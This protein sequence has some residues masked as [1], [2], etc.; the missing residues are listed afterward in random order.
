M[1]FALCHLKQNCMLAY[2]YH[3]RKVTALQVMYSGVTTREFNSDIY[4]YV[5]ERH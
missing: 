3:F 5:N 4:T 1:C 2:S